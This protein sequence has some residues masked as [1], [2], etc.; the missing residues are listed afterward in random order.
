M[1]EDSAMQDELNAAIELSWRGE[2][3]GSDRALDAAEGGRADDGA[4]PMQL[5]GSPPIPSLL[6][7]A[8]GYARS[9]GAA[10]SEGQSPGSLSLSFDAHNTS[11]NLSAM[12]A[13]D[14]GMW[15]G[16]DG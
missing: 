11:A 12:A 2:R 8:A 9:H 15:M 1:D 10:E 16:L 14:N 4:A 3:D 6:A 7:A 5:V 13:M